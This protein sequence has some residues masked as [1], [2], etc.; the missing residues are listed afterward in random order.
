MSCRRT[1]EAHTHHPTSIISLE[2]SSTYEWTGAR[3]PLAYWFTYHDWTFTRNWEDFS[4]YLGVGLPSPAMMACLCM[5]R[6]ACAQYRL[7][8]TF[9]FPL[10]CH[11]KF[12]A[13]L[14]RRLG[15]E[16][17]DGHRW[18]ACNGHLLGWSTVFVCVCVCS[19][20]ASS[21]RIE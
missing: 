15:D 12:L 19:A 4:V 13:P 21:L 2:R 1:N 10:L 17:I 20:A 7:A 9:A 6:T 16:R 18:M 8:F 5:Y 14:E 11:F 3:S